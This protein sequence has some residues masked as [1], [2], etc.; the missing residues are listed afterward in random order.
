MRNKL[1]II[2]PI[3]SS[4]DWAG[5]S[6]Y[7]YPKYL[8]EINNIPLIEYVLENLSSIQGE[9]NFFFILK[10]EDCLKY[11]IDNIVKLLVPNAT[12]IL[13]KNNTKGAICSILMGIDKIPQN[14][15]CLIVNSDQVLDGNMMEYLSFYRD[16][17]ADAGILTFKSVHPRWSYALLDDHVVLQTA[18]KK[19][20]S[21]HAMVGFYYFRSFSLF[22]KAAFTAILNDDNTN[23]QFYTSAVLNYL[24]LQNMQVLQYSIPDQ[25]HHSFYSPQLIKEFEQFIIKK[26]NDK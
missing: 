24:I 3:A 9:I 25:E 21:K 8:V 7:L 12:V 19:P 1:N 14:E 16:N 11:H 23:G 22:V 17:K 4:A 18:E 20:I 5:N 13:L 2:M 6:D 10:E 26:K 15:E